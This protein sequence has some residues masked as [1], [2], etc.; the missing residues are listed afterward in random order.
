MKK[1]V[2]FTI[3]LILAFTQQAL[4]RMNVES[5]IQSVINAF[6]QKEDATLENGKT[7]RLPVHYYQIEGLVSVGRIDL[8]AARSV[9]AGS[10]LYPAPMTRK[11]GVA[12]VY[13]VNHPNNTI[14]PYQ[15]FVVLVAATADSRLADNNSKN[16]NFMRGQL[17]KALLHHGRDI[18]AR[19]QNDFFF[20]VPFI[21]VTTQD[22]LLA[23]RD[24]WKLPKDIAKFENFF[25]ALKSHSSVRGPNCGLDFGFTHSRDGVRLPLY[26]DFNLVGLWQQ[27]RQ[28][29]IKAPMFARGEMLVSMYRKSKGD[30][31][32]PDLNTQCGRWFKNVGYRPLLW[33]YV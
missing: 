9:M 4:A 16:R 22:A 23:G 26:M 10:G 19:H 3:S 31:F 11:Y 33:Q 7:F 28:R 2:Y 6:P 1:Y 17:A 21:S 24:V 30:Y 15:E 12:I 27:P 32:N 25:S 13:A 14:G 5:A 29:L 18:G 8:E 20:H